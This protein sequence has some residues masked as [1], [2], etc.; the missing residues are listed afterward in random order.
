MPSFFSLA[1]SR[2][3][4]MGVLIF[5]PSLRWSGFSSTDGDGRVLL[6]NFTVGGSRFRIINVYTPASVTSANAFFLSVGT[7]FLDSAPTILC[8]DFNCVKDSVRDVRGPGQGRPNWNATE[9]KTVISH[10]HL[11][12][13]WILKQCG[14]F[15]PTWRR[16]ISQSRLDRFYV[17][18]ELVPAVVDIRVETFP[19]QATY[20]LHLRSLASYTVP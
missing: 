18:Q 9:L 2:A 8:G 7:Y 14:N 5:N 20:N 19:H 6:Y 10:Y 17:S 3:C 12:D 15:T 11:Q 4:G 13:A 1:T 16:G